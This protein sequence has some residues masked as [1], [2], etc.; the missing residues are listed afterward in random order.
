MDAPACAGRERERSRALGDGE[1][2]PVAVLVRVELDVAL[3]VEALDERGDLIDGDLGLLDEAHEPA[4]VGAGRQQDRAA[5]FPSRPAR[6]A[7]W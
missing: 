2:D 4:E 1:Q 7:S 5:G 6:P 3:G